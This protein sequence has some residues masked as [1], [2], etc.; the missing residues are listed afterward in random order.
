MDEIGTFAQLDFDRAKRC[1]FPE[2]VYGAGKTPEQVA[3]IMAALVER[4]GLVL[5]TRA[6]PEHAACVLATAATADANHVASCSLLYIDRRDTPLRMTGTEADKVVAGA[7]GEGL[8][9]VCCAGTSDLPVAEEAALTARIMGSRVRLV[10]DIGIAGVHRVV[11]RA[12]ELRKARCLIAVAGM[13]GALP[14]LIAGLVEVP[15]IAVPTS[16]GYGASFG[17]VAA[18]LGMLNS[19]A[20]GVSV[21][22]IDN[23]FGAGVIAHRVNCPSWTEGWTEKRAEQ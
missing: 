5:C 13:E 10:S 1:G 8:V 22:N 4:H 15:V 17:G 21:V 9:I 14:T 7:G 19:C 6:T 20:G 3:A 18:L 23:G 16:V 12:D 2:V 11:A